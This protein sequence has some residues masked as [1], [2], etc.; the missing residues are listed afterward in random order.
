MKYREKCFAD[1]TQCTLQE[2]IMK[3]RWKHGENFLNLRL[4]GVNV[5]YL[6]CEVVG[7]ETLVSS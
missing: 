6:T 1:S 4:D 3:M 5:K 7:V 2:I